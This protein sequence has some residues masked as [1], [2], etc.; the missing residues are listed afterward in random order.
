MRLT[1]DE[2]ILVTCILLALLAGAI[3][4]R[5][6]DRA[7]PLAPATQQATPAVSSHSPENAP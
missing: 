4:K 7:R 2:I 6:R 5:H 1:R 3:I